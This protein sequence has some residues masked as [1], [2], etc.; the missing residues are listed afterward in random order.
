MTTLALE[1]ALGSFSVAVARDDAILAQRCED[2][3][4]ALELG[5]A[6][7][8]GA[9]H[10]AGVAAGDLE[11]V[12]VGIGPGGFTGLRIALS[13]AKA[14]ALAWRL[15][16]VAVSSYDV[17]DG[18]ASPPVLTVVH[19]RAGVVCARYRTFDSIA[20]AC[21]RPGDVVGRLLQGTEN[22]IVAGDAEDVR[23]ALAER[24]IRVTIVPAPPVAA[25]ALALIAARRAPARTLHEVRPEY[26]E[27]PAATLPRTRGAR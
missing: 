23:E 3:R 4:Q 17:F 16:L 12:A 18:D 2:R 10:E 19:G 13:Y 15:P 14:L 8:A 7:V 11:R 21:G 1:G 24:A 22:V 20:T 6:L 26:G 27:L 5:L 9:M 25:V